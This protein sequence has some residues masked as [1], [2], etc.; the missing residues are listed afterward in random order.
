MSSQ[1]LA[2]TMNPTGPHKA[3]LITGG[4][5]FI[6]S[7]LV[8][9][10]LSRDYRVVVLDALTY[11]AS[12]ENLRDASHHPCFA[13]VEGDICNQALVRS[14]LER[15]LIDQVYHLAA[16]S[17]VNN[18]ISGPEPFI[19]TNVDGTF[20]LLEASRDYWYER[21]RPSS[22]RFVHVSTDEVF[23]DLGPDEPPFD[24]LT[25]YSPSSPYSA[26]KAASDHLAR[27]WG[28]TFGLPV[29]VTNCSNNFG[30]RQHHEKLM[31]TMVRAAISGRQLPVYGDGS[32]VRDWLYVTDHCAGLLLAGERGRVGESYCIGGGTEVTNLTLVRRICTL[33][34]EL[35]PRPDGRSYEEQIAF[36]T[37]RPGHDRRYAIDCS[38]ARTQLGYAPQH[39]L[40]TALRATINSLIH[41]AIYA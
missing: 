33:L 4:A 18:S 31:P 41:P 11:A 5:G 26:S 40:E 8:D 35:Q 17:H 1:P 38:K 21:Q 24:E 6:G 15:H 36:V 32:N 19:R 27:A 7:H 10:C 34:D 37:D 13:F 39:S 14:L 2:K 22:F 25:P 3:V 16:E 30:P 29:I 28:R 12:F 9:L 23:G 20:R